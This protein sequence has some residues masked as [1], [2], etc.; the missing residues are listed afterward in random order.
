MDKAVAE[1][2]RSDW[3]ILKDIVPEPGM[4]NNLMTDLGEPVRAQQV[5]AA[6]VRYWLENQMEG[7]V[8]EF[9]RLSNATRKWVETYNGILNG[10]QKN[11]FGER[12][13]NFDVRVITHSDIASFVRKFP[14]K[15]DRPGRVIDAEGK[16]VREDV[17]EV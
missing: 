13:T 11:K 5:L 4:M 9:G 1:V 6:Q 7:D 14:H 16:E 3:F 15:V 12:N 8:K 17:Y 2:K 10:L